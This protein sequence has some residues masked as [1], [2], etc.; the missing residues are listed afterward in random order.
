MSNFIVSL[1]GNIVAASS[2]KSYGTLIWMPLVYLDRM[3]SD[4]YNAKYRAGAF[5]I[6]FGFTYSSLFSCA[7]ENVLPAGNDISAILPRW[8]SMRRAFAVCQILTVAI[9]PWYLLGSAS[10]FISFLASYQVF[11]FPSAAILLVDYYVI[12]RGRLDLKWMYTANRE[13]KFW[14]TCGINWRAC[15]A[16]LV[17]V[18]VNFAGFLHAMGAIDASLALE[19]S[20]YFAWITSGTAAGLVYYLLARFFPQASY[21]ENK[22]KKFQEWSQDEIEE[23][24]GYAHAGRPDDEFQDGL[25]RRSPTEKDDG[26]EVSIHQA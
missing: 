16:W 22:G 25:R 1:F 8:L 20:Y 13:G 12:N 24:A 19:R 17:G 18:A 23:Y 3:L 6:A 4:S 7:F 21:L 11:L 14:Y 15:V 10:I 26:A 5:F 2:R 9:C